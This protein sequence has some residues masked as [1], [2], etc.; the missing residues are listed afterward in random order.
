MDQNIAVVADHIPPTRSKLNP[1]IFIPVILIIVVIIAGFVVYSKLSVKTISKSVS[2]PK[3]S[4]AVV[5][6][7]KRVMEQEIKALFTSTTD[8]NI[9]SFLNLASVEKDP[10]KRYQ[11]YVKT[12][13]LMLTVVNKLPVAEQKYKKPALA[14][15]KKYA[16][17]LVGYKESDFPAPK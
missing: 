12:Y 4:S 14:T 16:S 15:L 5:A 2:K 3:A 13:S 17:T 7:P 1:K 9:I 11:Y 8:K 10:A 6:D